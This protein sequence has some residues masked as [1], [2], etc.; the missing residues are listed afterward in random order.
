[1]DGQ[2]RMFAPWRA[3]ITLIFAASLLALASSLANAQFYVRSP[4][5]EKGETEIEEHG[6]ILC[7]PWR[8]RTAQ[9]VP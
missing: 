7:R 1:M 2:S 3:I 4:D 6:A 5:V 8:G 9:A